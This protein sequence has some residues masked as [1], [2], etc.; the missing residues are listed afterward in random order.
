MRRVDQ[1][2]RVY[3][4]HNGYGTLESIEGPACKIK[5]DVG[6]PSWVLRTDVVFVPEGDN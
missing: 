4:L 1:V 3:E 5:W 6:H 2:I